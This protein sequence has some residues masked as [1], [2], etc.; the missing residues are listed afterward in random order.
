[1]SIGTASILMPAASVI[2]S[3]C[4]TVSMPPHESATAAGAITFV[5]V[6]INIATVSMFQWSGCT[7]VIRMASGS[8]NPL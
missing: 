2:P 5:L 7:S 6:P 4:K 1:M 8:P 3:F